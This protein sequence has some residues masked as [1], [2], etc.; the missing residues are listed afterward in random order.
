MPPIHVL[1]RIILALLVVA[2]VIKVVLALSN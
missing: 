2:A 1:H